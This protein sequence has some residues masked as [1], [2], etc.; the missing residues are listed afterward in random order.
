MS[1]ATSNEKPEA[2]QLRQRVPAESS[3]NHVEDRDPRTTIPPI[4]VGA[5]PSAESSAEEK[6]KKTYGRTPDGTGKLLFPIIPPVSP[7]L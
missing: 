5:P 2:A 4:Y 3:G 1:T 7:S 6:S